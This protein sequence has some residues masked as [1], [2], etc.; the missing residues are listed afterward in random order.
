MDPFNSKVVV[1]TG[2]SRG[3]GYNVAKALVAKGCKV[4]IGDLLDA[5]G[6]AAV[7]EFN[8]KYCMRFY[9]YAKY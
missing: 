3:I 2:G 8:D 5:E 9:M 4:V 1:I 6:Q 7:K